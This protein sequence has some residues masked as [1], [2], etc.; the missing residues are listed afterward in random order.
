MP[1]LRRRVAAARGRRGDALTKTIPR[2]IA[3]DGVR[4]PTREYQ[5]W[6][7]MRK[8]CTSQGSPDWQWYGGRGI[9]V[10]A[11]WDDY[12]AFIADM[13]PRPSVAHSIDRIDNNG[14]YEPGNCR[15][16]TAREQAQNRRPRGPERH[17]RKQTIN[18]GSYCYN[19]RL[20]D[21]DVREIRASGE[22]AQVVAA[23]LGVAAST[24]YRIRARTAWRHVA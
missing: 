12:A 19:A 18:R 17:P 2:R 13:G 22:P 23:R 9:R 7:N 3:V 1:V 4:K 20:T 8:R 16:A 15:W 14:N 21:D 5:A 24:I 6:K 10:C 11:R